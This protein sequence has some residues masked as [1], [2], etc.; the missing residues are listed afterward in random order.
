MVV[1]TAGVTFLV[2]NIFTDQG[3]S[4]KAA[5]MLP[6]KNYPLYTIYS[7]LQCIVG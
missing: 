2:D 1:F 7:R 4:M 3:Q 6:L 5:K